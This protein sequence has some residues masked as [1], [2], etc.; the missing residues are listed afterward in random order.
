MV[1]DDKNEADE[2]KGKHVRLHRF[3]VTSCDLAENVFNL[4]RPPYLRAS[5]PD[6]PLVLCHPF[7]AC[8][9]LNKKRARERK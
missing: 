8:S 2:K 3:L 7:L 1:V 4:P 6:H 9:R 5:K